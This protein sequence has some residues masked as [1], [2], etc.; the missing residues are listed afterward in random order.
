VLGEALVGTGEPAAAADALER[1]RGLSDSSID[2]GVAAWTDALLGRALIES[3]RDH[4]RGVRL[5]AGAWH[6]I[7]SDPRLDDEE[8]ELAAWLKRRGLRLPGR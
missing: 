8:A 1:A 4:A 6:A 5:I 7:A 2:P 3:G